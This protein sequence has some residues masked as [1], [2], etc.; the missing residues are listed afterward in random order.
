MAKENTQ[1]SAAPL[2]KSDAPAAVATRGPSQ[3]ILALFST[4]GSLKVVINKSDRKTLPMMVKPKDC[5]IDGILQGKIVK[6][7]DSPVTTIKGK[8]LWLELDGG[9]EVLFPCTGVIRSAL[10]PDVDAD[11]KKDLQVALDKHIGKILTLQ[12]LPN[13]QTKKGAEEGKT[14]DMYLFDVY[15]TEAP[16]K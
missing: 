6:S 3:A 1:E 12:R 14:R 16:K 4:S 7:I 11:S 8:L 9:R 13:G 5:P 10:A 15:L 2:T